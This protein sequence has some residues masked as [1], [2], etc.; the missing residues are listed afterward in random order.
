[1]SS[2]ENHVYKGNCIAFHPVLFLSLHDLS[3]EKKNESE[4]EIGDLHES[5]V[6]APGS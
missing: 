1:M 2:A 4:P 3:G 6:G 5:F